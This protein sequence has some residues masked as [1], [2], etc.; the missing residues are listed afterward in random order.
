[1]FI[2]EAR[3]DNAHC[4][5]SHNGERSM[6]KLQT[7][8]KQN[9]TKRQAHK[10]HTGV[11]DEFSIKL[12]VAPLKRKSYQMACYGLGTSHTIRSSKYM[13]FHNFTDIMNKQ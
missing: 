12:Q 2:Y 8:T 10:Y 6:V 3:T 4:E 13:S 5:A 11:T 7:E 9:Q 1:M